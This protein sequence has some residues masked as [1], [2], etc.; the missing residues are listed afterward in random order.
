MSEQSEV[1]LSIRNLYKVFGENP[2]QALAMGQDGIDKARILEE[3][4]CTLGVRDASFDVLKGEIFVVMGLSGSGKSTLVRLLNRLIEP[5]FGQVLID[6]EDVASMTEERL[7]LIRR[8]KIAMVFQSFA[9]MPHMSVLENAAFGLE[10][11]GMDEKSRIDRARLAL[12]QVGLAQ[13]ESAS[14]ASLSGGMKQR[15]GLARALANDP[16]ILLMDEAFSALD[17]LIRREM[18]DQLL[19]LQQQEQRTIVFISHDLDE[20]IRIGDRIAIMQDGVVVQVGT[21]D[22]ILNNPASNYVASFFNDVDLGK[23]ATARDAAYDIMLLTS[24]VLRAQAL[25]QLVDANRDVAVVVDQRGDVKGMVD[26]ANL[27]Q[28]NVSELGLDAVLQPVETLAHDAPLNDILGKV[29]DSDLPLPVV[30]D[31][32]NVQGVVDAGSVLRQLAAS[33]SRLVANTADEEGAE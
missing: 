31:E 26:Q 16:D 28:E 27:R 1:K 3:T 11:A 12:A 10:V 7:Q 33:E 13:W 30:C 21:P 14:P 2:G 6:G 4:G 5:S 9:L 32:G 19:E 23:V 22:E 29:G 15:V 8:N 24:D 17:P 20:A 25:E 18:Q